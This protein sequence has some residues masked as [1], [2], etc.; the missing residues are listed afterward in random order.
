MIDNILNVLDDGKVS[1]I[2]DDCCPCGNFYFFSGY[3]R[4]ALLLEYLQWPAFSKDCDDPNGWFT[5]CCTN[6]CF[7]ELVTYLG[8]DSEAELLSIGIFEYSL[9]GDK[10]T[11]CSLYEYI[12]QNNIP[13]DE[14]LDFI[15]DV[16]NKG[17]VIV[18]DVAND[19]Q[20]FSSIDKFVQFDYSAYPFLCNPFAPQPDPC[21]CYPQ[22][23]C[24]LTIKS[25]L[26]KYLQF[27]ELLNP[28][29]IP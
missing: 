3:D 17:I 25:N 28:P 1:P 13:K 27:Q 16:L 2:C 8:A 26:Q 18:C 19:I 12:V 7:D 14:A 21:Q 20:I 5:E 22:D 29:P 15:K 11:L 6:T 4:M 10:S 24:C 9:I 23:G